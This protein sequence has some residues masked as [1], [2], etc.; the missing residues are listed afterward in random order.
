M[1]PLGQKTS[2]FS[3]FY[4]YSL[5]KSQQKN[6]ISYFIQRFTEKLPGKNTTL[7]PP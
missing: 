3:H 1:I 4:Q 2:D 7:I 6:R 5:F